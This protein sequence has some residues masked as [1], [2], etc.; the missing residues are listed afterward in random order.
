[1]TETMIGI[2]YAGVACVKIVK[3]GYNAAT[4][5]DSVRGAF[6]YNSKWAA[7][8]RYGY[9]MG[10][11]ASNNYDYIPGG[12]GA[13]DY[14]WLADHSFQV[15]R[16]K[17]SPA[18][19]YNFPLIELKLIDTNGLFLGESFEYQGI[20]GY[21]ERGVRLGT[22]GV[23]NKGWCSG[24][25]SNSPFTGSMAYGLASTSLF[26]YGTSNEKYGKQFSV[27]QLPG[28]ETAILD[29]VPLAPVPGQDSIVID[30]TSLRVAK[31]GFN[32]HTATST[33]LA[34][35][36]ANTPAK[37]VAA[38]DIYLPSG[39]SVYDCGF[40]LP[41]NTVV[42]VHYYEG[43]VVYY[44]ASP[45]ASTFG[46]SYYI[47]GR[48]IVFVNSGRACRARFMVVANDGSG[49][50]SGSNDVLRQFNDGT[51]DVVQFLRPG[52][53]NNPSFSDI[54]LDS[55]WPCIQILA[56]GVIY[57]SSGVQTYTV[58]FNG[59]GAFPMVKYSTIH[60]AGSF[61]TP[62]LTFSFSKR[63]RQPITAVTYIDK[64]SS[65]YPPTPTGD[66]TF[67]T[68]GP[69]YAT[70]HTHIGLPTQVWLNSA[71]DFDNNRVRAEYDTNP[72]YAIRYYIFGIAK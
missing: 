62:D 43:G 40:N 60:G 12:S 68:L 56:E 50:T 42:D 29:G 8:V 47:S 65:P 35:D 63:V 28:D 15:Y 18:H 37:I 61:A 6:L 52:A 19:P 45:A 21:Q 3:D 64:L 9:S 22:G 71:Q 31:P 66:C 34:I 54:A 51:Q 72:P 14:D 2:D 55:R 7:D 57:L 4:T 69:D 49:Y 67:C 39:T 32:V 17:G 41:S 46:A 30:S 70:F 38:D 58:P 10:I 25:S 1:M 11:P 48:S 16:Y 33:Q 27:W 24:L 20:R 13:G 26:K 5:H 23:V 36:T 53:S 59:A 44:P